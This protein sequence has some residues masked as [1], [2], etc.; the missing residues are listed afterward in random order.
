MLKY[1]KF[2]KDLLMNKR[3]FE[4]GST[5]MFSEDSSTIFQK[6]MPKKMKDQGVLLSLA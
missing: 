4:E 1:M 2:L 5:M 3:M 6:K